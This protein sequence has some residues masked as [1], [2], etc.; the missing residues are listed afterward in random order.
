VFLSEKKS[1]VWVLAAVVILGGIL[2]WLLFGTKPFLLVV[3]F[4]DTGDLKKGAPVVWKGFSVGRV[5][6]IE[7]LVDSQIGVT[8]RLREDYADRITRGTEFVLKRSALV[9]LVGQTSIEITTPASPGSPFVSGEKVQGISTRPPTLI[10]EAKRVTLEFWQELKNEA[11]R[12][13]EQ[14]QNSPFRREAAALL[15]ELASLGEKGAA[16]AE[17]KFERFREEHRQEID[18]AVKKLQELRDKMRH[19]GDEDGAQR[20]ERQIESLKKDT[21]R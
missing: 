19:A 4:D 14:Y 21:P 1:T 11:S 13:L 2:L 9:G 10:A 20:M 16:Q 15:E 7:P 17:E 18:R 8:V 12:L 6:K 3:L 5:D